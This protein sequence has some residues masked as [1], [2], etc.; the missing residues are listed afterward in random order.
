VGVSSAYGDGTSLTPSTFFMS[1]IASTT[2]VRVRSS[3]TVPPSGATTTRYADVPLS[4]GNVRL[5]ES[6]ASCDSVPGMSKELRVPPPR[7]I[8]ATPATSR[9]TIQAP[10]TRRGWRKAQRPSA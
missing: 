1:A 4:S 3:V 9:T 10:R 8:A 5:S 7:P 6:I 2:R